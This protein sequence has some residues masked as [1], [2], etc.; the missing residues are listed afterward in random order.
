MPGLD[1]LELQEVLA[2]RGSA[3][4]IIFLTGNATVPSS[5]RA[6]KR[7]ALDFLVKPVDELALLDAIRLALAKD[8][9]ERAK[10]HEGIR[11]RS[12]FA[13]LTPREHEVLTHVLAGKLNKQ[14]AADLGT[15]EKTVKVHRKRAMEKLQVSSLAE[16]VLL[17]AQAGITAVAASHR[18]AE[19][20]EKITA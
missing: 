18:P 19:T 10:R 15:V 20:F 1:G 4:P 9:S 16:L 17:A 5:V 13:R 12:L 11:L 8:Q 2:A 3:L 6:L 14:I 7:G